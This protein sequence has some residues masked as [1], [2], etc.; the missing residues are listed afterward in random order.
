MT[1]IMNERLDWAIHL[2]E[3][4]QYDEGLKQ[5]K[6]ILKE[7][8]EETAFE[9]A[10]H[11]QE[12]GM[13]EDARA[14]L[15]R[16]HKQ[17]PSDSHILM[18]L[19][20]VDIDLDQED[21]AIDWLM[22]IHQLDENY[23][24]A[25]VLLADLYQAQGL[26]EA[27]ERRLLEAHKF[28]PHEPILIFALAEFYASV[29]RAGQ[30]AT[31][32]KQVLHADTLKH[33]NVQLKLAEALSYNGQ[34]EEALIYYKKGL[35]SDKPLN[36]LFGYGMTAFKVEQYQT[37]ITALEELK[38]LDPQYSTLYPLLAKA[39]EAEGAVDEAFATIEAGIKIDEF[40]EQLFIEASDLAMKLKDPYKAEHYLEQ[41]LAI[42]PENTEA[43]KKWVEIKREQEDHEAI[44][45][46]LEKEKA[47][48]ELLWY[49][50]SA[51]VEEEHL[52]KAAK[53]YNQIVSHFKE[54]PAF[55]KEYGE[56]LWQLG[57]R[58][59][60]LQMLQDSLSLDPENEELRAFVE[61]IEQDF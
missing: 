25:Q 56:V 49:L 59:E 20:E 17:H 24:S 2:I 53:I 57:E 11:Y 6:T 8:D 52:E 46:L 3:S 48:P 60:A 38:E 61:R 34:F 21:Q 16:L 9:I 27:A 58:S 45:Q 13:A 4:G 15:T 31:L 18:A 51:Y 33:E 30:A 5:I 19:A 36:S 55:L 35:E 28:S 14:I 43:I 26:E 1:V 50:A 41:L 7:A 42:D 32:Y 40:N 22:S 44:I 10:T 37:T 54:D 23:L 29:G 12:W 47:D 39:Y